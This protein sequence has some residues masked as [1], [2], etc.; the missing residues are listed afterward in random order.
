MDHAKIIL[1]AYHIYMRSSNETPKSLNVTP[2]NQMKF[3]HSQQIL[4][5]FITIECEY[6]YPWIH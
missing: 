3:C 5:S 4:Q 1:Q 6:N 2:P